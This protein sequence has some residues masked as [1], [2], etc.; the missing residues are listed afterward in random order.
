MD[1]RVDQELVTAL[2]SFLAMLM[3]G[4]VVDALIL[5][6]TVQLSGLW[7]FLFGPLLIFA[8]FLLDIEGHRVVKEIS[9]QI[10]RRAS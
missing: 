6:F 5:Y 3:L 4:G 7:L 1:V 8:Y 9:G 10:G 2:A